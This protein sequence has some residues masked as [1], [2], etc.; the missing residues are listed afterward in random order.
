MAG[1]GGSLRLGKEAAPVGG[2]DM[3]PE[4]VYGLGGTTGADVGGDG[5]LLDVEVGEVSPAFDDTSDFSLGAAPEAESGVV[6]P[7]D[8]TIGELRDIALVRKSV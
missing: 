8:A 2:A 5:L 6:S 1:L 4:E 7:E 3:G